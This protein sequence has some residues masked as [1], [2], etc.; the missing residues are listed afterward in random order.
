MLKHNFKLFIRNIKKYKSTFL[1]NI[2]GLSTG[3]ACVLLIALWV[4]DE[5]GID[6]FHAN[7]SQL[8]QV[9]G[10]FQYADNIEIMPYLPDLLAETML[11]EIPE[12]SYASGLTPPEWF[13]KFPLS[14]GDKNLKATGQ[15]VGKDY[16][17]MFS[18]PLLEGNKSE[19]LKDKNSIVISESLSKKLFNT[20][21]GVIGKTIKWELSETGDYLHT[22]TGIFKDIPANST[23][24][25]EFLLPYDKFI[26]LSEKT[27]KNMNWGNYGPSTFVVLKKGTNVTA[28]NTKIYD[29]IKRKDKNAEANLLLKKYSENY[30]YGR[31]ENGVV[32]GGRI[33]YIKL[34]ST[35][36]I[37]ILLIACI[38]FMN[39]STA[40]AS[41]RFREI[42]IKK[43]LGSKRKSL[44]IQYLGESLLMTFL[45]L[46]VALMLVVLLMPKFNEITGKQLAL[47][48]DINLVYLIFGATVITGI[49]A[50]S[51]P[52]LY[53]SGFNTVKTLKGNLRSSLGEVWVRKGL[54]VSQFALSV[55]LI[56]SVLVVYKQIA[57]VQNQN[58]GYDKDNIIYFQKEGKTQQN[59]ETFIDEIKSIPGVINASGMQ[60]NVL[61][62]GGTTVGVS[63]EGKDPKETI[64]FG[65][66]SYDYEMIETLGMKITSGR[67]FSKAFPS[68][69][70]KII[71]NETA[72]KV[73]GFQG[74][75][76]GRMVNVW[77]EDRQIIGVV[78]DFHSNSFRNS[79]EPAFIF[80]R[81]KQT[82]M[83]LANIEAGKERETIKQLTKVYGAFNPG[84]SFDFKF[85][86]QSYQALY[87]S[88]QRIAT[89]SKYFAGLAMIISCLGL[90]GLAAF[91]AARRRKEIGI[92]K[93][94]G[95]SNTQITVLLSSEFAKLVLI[96]IVIALP[97]AYLLT[98]DWLADFAYGI[99]LQWW[100][101]ALA[102]VSAL[103]V[104]LL[105]VS[106]QAIRAAHKNPIGAL[107]EE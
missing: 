95:Q 18:F 73:M 75:A 53:L 49:M 23:Q 80:L 84:Y 66:L 78:K 13:G 36:A 92:R 38:N 21:D 74:S 31:Y 3:L 106:T 88:E 76:I 17:N 56:V 6:K 28:L 103:V 99:N 45:A 34:F 58:I 90:F 35:I 8:Y 55:I 16:F 77:G 60:G 37:F 27:G 57:F 54:V 71:L 96:A 42:G 29:Y 50:G 24:Q 33:D 82:N 69:S 102:G 14:A 32:A 43:A 67:S 79:I 26:A 68:D 20:T 52:S 64:R 4:I 15:F 97:I 19:V 63:W 2:I 81:P 59:Y 93:V 85:L 22:V 87:V 89:L 47:G 46:T 41:R 10:R 11:E 7:D 94:L 5:L 25:F 48:F 100:Y 30:L 86:D 9:M 44:V 98:S 70:T 39:L 61:G 51:Y 40:N 91:T 62:A 65:N 83:I 104:A 105:T 101:F 12:I 72:I 1:I 107:R